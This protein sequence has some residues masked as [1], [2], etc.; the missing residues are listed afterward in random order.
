MTIPTDEAAEP[1][2]EDLEPLPAALSRWE[3]RTEQRIARVRRVQYLK[4]TLYEGAVSL[5]TALALMFTSRAL[6]R[7]WPV[8]PEVS[9]ATV[10]LTVFSL[11]LLITIIRWSWEGRRR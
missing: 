1:A 3:R 11:V 2:D 10:L 5:V 7:D 9:F 6:H 8:I 4:D